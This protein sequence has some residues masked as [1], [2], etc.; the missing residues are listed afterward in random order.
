MH[1]MFRSMKLKIGSGQSVRGITASI[2]S[3]AAMFTLTFIS[4]GQSQPLPRLTD[5]EIRDFV[6]EAVEQDKVA[7]GIAVGI[8]DEHGSRVIACGKLKS[9]G[10]EK[11]DGNTIFEIGSITKVFT[12]LLLQDMVDHGEVK[13]D[14]PISK[15][16]PAS[17][18]T[19][20]RNGKQITL[21]HLATHTSGLPR[22]PFSMW[23]L[24]LH[25]IDPYASFRV[26]DFYKFLSN[27]KLTNDIG[28]H[29]EYSN[30]GMSL[31]GHVLSLKAGTNYEALVR[32]RI[33]KPLGMESTWVVLSPELKKRMAAAYDGSGNPVAN[34]TPSDFPAD[35]ELRSSANDLLKFLAANLGYANS[36]LADQMREIQIPREKTDDPA[37]S[38]GLGWMIKNDTRM[39]WHNGGTSGYR[40]YIALDQLRRRGIVVL[41][42]SDNEVDNIGEILAGIRR[43]HKV[44]QIKP[45]VFER[46]LGKYQFDR[47]RTMTISAKGNRYFLRVT[48]Q[49]AFEMFP[50]SDTKFFLKDLDGQATFV[51][52]KS[53][54]A[55]G[56]I[57]QQEG[58]TNPEMKKLK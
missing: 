29:F 28:T 47:E 35:G 44:T 54:A 5:A 26:K 14:D 11:V 18:Q 23:Y 17:V 43:L 50:E 53:G 48:G 16:L 34:W 33:C 32:Q 10:N 3:T 55:T 27:Y 36:T 22:L 15:Y 24:A 52:D 56:L 42:N 1:G 19:P 20:S 57:W 25:P 46:Y 40:S 13:L 39:V 37:D 58:E 31:L 30:A 2:F 12:T 8:I 4:T 7:P 45:W 38:I 49:R 21:Y 51:M 6:Q 41:A 9:D